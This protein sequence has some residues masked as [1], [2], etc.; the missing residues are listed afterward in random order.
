MTEQVEEQQGQPLDLQRYLNIVRRRHLHFLIPAFV[1]WLVVWGSSWFLQARY[2]SGTTIL[3][4]Q[5]SISKEYITPSVNDDLQERL[6]SI[7]QQI[8]SR[9]RLLTIIMT[10]LM[11]H[12]DRWPL[13]Y[14]LIMSNLVISF[15][16]VI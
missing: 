1:G 5:P 9:T 12:E 14:F 13:I 4:Q 8:L 2:K 15:D 11:L 6:Q 16:K 7:K 3:V 10:L